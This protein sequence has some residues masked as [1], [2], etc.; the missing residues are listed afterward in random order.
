[1]KRKFWVSKNKMGYVVGEGDCEMAQL[2]FDDGP[3][4]KLFAAAPELLEACE[5]ILADTLEQGDSADATHVTL[6]S[7]V[8]LKAKGGKS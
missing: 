6:L 2:D 8:I 3:A 1:M 5:K 7:A 4:A